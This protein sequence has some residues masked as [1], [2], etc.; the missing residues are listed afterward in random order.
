VS[1]PELARDANFARGLGALALFAALAGA[2]LATSFGPAAWFPADASVVGNV[3]YSL[4]GLAGQGG[5]ADESF[6]AA[7]ELVDIVLVAALVGAVTLARK[8]GGDA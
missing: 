1:R 6:L 8:D 3:G 2:F 5:L 7:F 4:V